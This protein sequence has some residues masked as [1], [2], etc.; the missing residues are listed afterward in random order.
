MLESSRM[1]ASVCIQ[2]VIS[3]SESHTS[4][5]CRTSIDYPCG[6]ALSTLRMTKALLDIRRQ[7]VSY[8]SRTACL[9][10]FTT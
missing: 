4:T 10:V 9:S 2:C 8:A 5:T 6:V 1:G 3:P 7:A